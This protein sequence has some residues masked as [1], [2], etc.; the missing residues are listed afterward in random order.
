MRI[1]EFARSGDWSQCQIFENMIF[2]QACWGDIFSG[3]VAVMEK[4]KRCNNA[5]G[6]ILSSCQTII[7]VISLSTVLDLNHHQ[8]AVWHTADIAFPPHVWT[9]AWLSFRY[10]S[11]SFS[12][13]DICK[14]APCFPKY[15]YKLIIFSSWKYCTQAICVSYECCNH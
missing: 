12:G 14:R 2:W 10:I 6:V 1:S 7:T 9:T 4:R 15:I 11:M 5:M 13:C 3:N 8:I